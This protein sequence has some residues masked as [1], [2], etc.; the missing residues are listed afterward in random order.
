VAKRF[1]QVVLVA[2]AAL[3]SPALCQA[4][5]FRWQAGQVLIYR[6]E[7]VTAATVASGDTKNETKTLLNL[8]K[9]WEIKGVDKAGIAT[10]QMSLIRLRLENIRPDGESLLFDSED[11][12]KSNPEMGK[13]LSEYVGKV[14]AILRVDSKG[15]VVEVKESRFGGASRFENELPFAITLPDSGLKENQ[16]WQRDYK[17][18]LEPPQGTG[19]KYDAAQNYVCKTLADN[20]ATIGIQTEIKS[21]PENTGDQEPLLQ[22]QPQGEVVFDLRLGLMKSATLVIDKE[23]KGTQGAS[24]SYRFR[25]KYKEEYVGNK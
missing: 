8:T 18:T 19:E 12:L 3:G 16:S 21:L 1:L 20:L 6:I 9:R 11:K 25:S 23:L 24:S 10:L 5:Q 13:Q 7:Q 15:K 2:L 22:Y 17:I 4:A 14:L